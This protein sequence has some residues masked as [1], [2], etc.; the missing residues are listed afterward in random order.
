MKIFALSF[1]LIVFFTGCAVYTTGFSSKKTSHQPLAIQFIIPSEHSVLKNAYV[2]GSDPRTKLVYGIHNSFF[3]S[4][5]DGGDHWTDLAPWPYIALEAKGGVV[6][7]IVAEGHIFLLTTKGNLLES[8]TLAPGLKFQ[9][10]SAPTTAQGGPRHLAA[11]GRPYG[12]AAMAGW[13][14][15]GEYTNAPNEIYPDAPRVLRYDIARHR[16]HI[17]F[18]TPHARHIHS[19]LVDDQAKTLF[20]SVGDEGYGDG[21]GVWRLDATQI[22]KG[23]GQGEDQAV[24]W[25]DQ[26]PQQQDRENYPV[27]MIIGGPHSGFPGDL[28]AASDLPG[29]HVMHVRTT[30]APGT[31]PIEALIIPP[32]G[33]PRETVRDVTEDRSTGVLYFWTTES[34]T[35][36]LYVSAPPYTTEEKVWSYNANVTLTRTALSGGFLMLGS[37]RFRISAPDAQH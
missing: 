27:D 32:S 23:Q 33:E 26:R 25:S 14:F 36:G 29:T 21:I 28:L 22:G 5:D 19:L 35:P 8:D 18:A 12:L 3:S 6:D 16:W 11:N 34:S 17:S 37:E 7:L 24:K 2:F 4:T 13:V 31:A 1:A 15:Q 10:V 20:V 9:D 30:Q